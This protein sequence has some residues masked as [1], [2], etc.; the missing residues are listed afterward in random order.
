[1]RVFSIFPIQTRDLFNLSLPRLLARGRGS[2]HTRSCY[3]QQHTHTEEMAEGTRS[4]VWLN[5]TRLHVD[6]ARCQK[7]NKSLGC[8]G[9][10][11]SNLSKHLSKVHHIQTEKCTVF[12][13]LSSSSVVP[14]TSNVSTSGMLCMLAATH[15]ANSM[16]QTWVND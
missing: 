2:L 13:C 14:S 9:G 8:K 6:N 1:M 7:C 12:D 4:E 3:M 16:V 15:G 5:F 11:T 10:N